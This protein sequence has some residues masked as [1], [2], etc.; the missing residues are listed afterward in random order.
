V[1][2]NKHTQ[3]K[4]RA[5]A[6]HTTNWIISRTCKIHKLPAAWHKNIT[7][8]QTSPHTAITVTTDSR[9]WQTSTEV[10]H[11][12]KGT[13]NCHRSN[14]FK[15]IR[16]WITMSGLDNHWQ[17]IRLYWLTD[18]FNGIHWLGHTLAVCQTTLVDRQI[19]Q[20]SLAW[21]HTGSESDYTGWQTNS[22][23]STG[24]N[25]NWQ[26]IRLCW[27]SIKFRNNLYLEERQ[28]IRLHLLLLDK[29]KC[30]LWL[31]NKPRAYMLDNFKNVLWLDLKLTVH[32]T[33]LKVREIQIYSMFKL[34]HYKQ[35]N[36]NN[37]NKHRSLITS[38]DK[39]NSLYK[40]TANTNSLATPHNYAPMMK[41]LSQLNCHEVCDKAVW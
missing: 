21:T 40:F 14:F 36:D 17:G 7:E 30:W 29:F 9:S 13:V 31:E 23:V 15:D 8:L 38:K 6:F 11:G 4:W 24:L 32:Q 5:E 26:D 3:P 39:I 18:K 2:H 35:R 19:Q 33:T 20:Y 22:T 10:W 1:A 34:T 37:W 28:N 16:M 27:L 12:R 41:C 25:T